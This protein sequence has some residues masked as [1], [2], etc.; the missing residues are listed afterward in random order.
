MGSSRGWDGSAVCAHRF[1]EPSSLAG[2]PDTPPVTL[3]TCHLGPGPFPH[4]CPGP[5]LQCSWVP[6][7]LAP[8]PSPWCP[9]HG[10]TS[11]CDAAEQCGGPSLPPTWR[12][13]S[14][15]FLLGAWMCPAGSQPESTGSAQQP[16]SRQSGPALPPVPGPGPVCGLGLLPGGMTVPA[17][18]SGFWAAL[19]LSRGPRTRAFWTPRSCLG[20]QHCHAMP[21]VSCPLGHPCLRPTGSSCPRSPGRQWGPVTIPPVASDLPSL[22]PAREPC[23]FTVTAACLSSQ[24]PSP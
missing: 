19:D 14:W 13:P 12:V 3:P 15:P 10:L 5:F 4:V 22:C 23:M 7:Q 2:L 16:R 11:T 6:G 8:G 24:A 18:A 21:M 1:P 9:L 20:P 17:L